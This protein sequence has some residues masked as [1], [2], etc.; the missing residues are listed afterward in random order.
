MIIN[1]NK[2]VELEVYSDRWIDDVDMYIERRR[3]DDDPFNL[4][5]E[6]KEDEDYVYFANVAGYERSKSEKQSGEPRAVTIETAVYVKKSNE[7]VYL[8][9][10]DGFTSLA[11]LNNVAYWTED[12][13]LERGVKKIRERDFLFPRDLT[14]WDEILIVE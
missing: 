14:K 2:R 5:F 3:F 11:C 7:V 6:L 8:D 1:L 4:F 10:Y 9:D 12:D 13:L